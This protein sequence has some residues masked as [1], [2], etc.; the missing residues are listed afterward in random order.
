MAGQIDPV[1]MVGDYELPEGLLT[2][3]GPVV[4]PAPGTLPLRGDLAHIALADRYLVA[5]YVVPQLYRIGAAD[6]ALKL[7]ASADARTVATLPAGSSFEVLDHAGAW[8]WG[9]V[10]PDG[11]TGYV[12]TAQLAEPGL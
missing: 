1:N 6:A 12:P 4:R 8:S 7:T 5:H 11:P 3:D 9:C 10:G 2:L